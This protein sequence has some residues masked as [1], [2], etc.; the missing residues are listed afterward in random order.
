[1]GQLVTSNFNSHN[2]KQF[3]ESLNE[4][5]NSLYYVFLG[6]HTSFTDDNIP[7]TQNNSPEDA[8]YQPYRD[9][10]YGKQVTTSD[11]KH[12][13][14]NNAWTSNTV[15]AQY[16]HRDGELKKASDTGDGPVDAIFKCIKKLYPHEVNLQLYNVHAVTEGTDAQATVSIR[17]EENG[18]TTV[19]QA[20]NTDTLVASADAYLNALNKLIIKR[21]K[22]APEPMDLS[23]SKY[24][25]E[26]DG[27]I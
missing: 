18:K 19:G 1:M 6:K 22:T 17:I 15:Y 4:T 27:T 12:M 14:A 5:A 11:I 8:Y 20:A 16:D 2:A 24:I 26:K 21:K 10:I 23:G 25:R 7:P 13:I 9:M 3:V